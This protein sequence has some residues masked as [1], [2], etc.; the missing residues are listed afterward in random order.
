MTALAAPVGQPS[1]LGRALGWLGPDF[2]I[3]FVFLGVFVVLAIVYGARWNFFQGS[4]IGAG[5]IAGGLILMTAIAHAPRLWRREPGAGITLRRRVR[6]VLRDF[7]PF[8]A[9]TIVYEHLYMYTGVIR[10]RHVDAALWALDVKLFGVEPVLWIQRFYHPLLTDVFAFA[11]GTYFPMPLFLCAMLQ[12][13][14]RR[15]DFRELTTAIIVAM[16][17]GFLGYIT[18]PAGPPRFYEPLYPLF[19]PPQLASALGLFEHTQEVWDAGNQVKVS[20]SFPSMHAGLSGLTLVYAWRFGDVLRA[21]RAL[22]VVFLVLS[23]LLW[24]STIYL[25]HHWIVD[26]FA[27][28]AVALTA[29][30]AAPWLRRVW[31]RPRPH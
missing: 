27:G 1:R 19:H 13:R 6:E 9:M 20:A 2:G 15:E 14:G 3:F 18:I 4:I 21:R 28:W 29:A 10:P 26:L 11:Y 16:C 7:A 5:A 24:T 8:I 31:P 17:I 30:C 25:R 12:L 22:F 23:L